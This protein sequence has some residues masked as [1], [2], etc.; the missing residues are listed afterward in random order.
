MNYRVEYRNQNWIAGD[1]EADSPIEAAK[2][3][4]RQDTDRRWQDYDDVVVFWGRFGREQQSFPL[5]DLLAGDASEK[6][7]TEAPAVIDSGSGK[8]GSAQPSFGTQLA[9]GMV[10]L[11]V[12]FGFFIF[13]DMSNPS[14]K[15]N[16]DRVRVG[17]SLAEVET[18][19]GTKLSIPDS[20][21]AHFTGSGKWWAIDYVSIVGPLRDSAQKEIDVEFRDG[22]V[23]SKSRSEH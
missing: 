20:Q 14:G 4:L 9:G 18:I 5:R 6:A 7:G 11:L 13:R 16:Y 1:I 8:P 2:L 21:R 10:I 19:L 17:M 22:V 15:A 12:V 23:V 3:Y